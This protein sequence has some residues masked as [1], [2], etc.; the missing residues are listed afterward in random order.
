MQQQI[1]MIKK[2]N[3]TTINATIKKECNNNK[4]SN[5]KNATTINK[6][7]HI[8]KKKCNNN[9]QNA[10]YFEKKCNNKQ[11]YYVADIFRTSRVIKPLRFDL[12]N[13]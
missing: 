13:P 12:K 1:N 10:T 11:N 2:P 4:H 3:A 6:M 9:K 8:S 7:Q 5:T